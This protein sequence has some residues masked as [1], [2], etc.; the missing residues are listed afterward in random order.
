MI[1]SIAIVLFFLGAYL[2]TVL[3]FEKASELAQ[4]RIIHVAELEKDHG[5]LDSYVINEL[6]KFNEIKAESIKFIGRADAKS[7]MIQELDTSLISTDENPFSDVI[8]FNVYSNAD[9][10]KL[11]SA[12]AE[13]TSVKSVHLQSIEMDALQSNI[14]KFGWLLLA[15]AIVFGLLSLALIFSTIQLQL[16]ADRFEIKTMELV[17]AED[18]FIKMPYFR[19]AFSLANW[20]LLIAGGVLC[21]CFVILKNGFVFFDEL[22]SYLKLIFILIALWLF[23]IVFLFG[24]N[25]YLI[26]KY[27][28]KKMQDLYR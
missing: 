7:F 12:I 15:L 27:L 22:L 18:R 2:T 5:G 26:K 11:K 14:K 19:R 28:S 6:K 8:L 4:E 23:S 3:H 21:F 24:S 25:N 10:A 13:L 20:S 9:M 16:Y 1:V 17:G